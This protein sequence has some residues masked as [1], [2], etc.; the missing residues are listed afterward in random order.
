MSIQATAR[1]LAK[2]ID[3]GG[4]LTTQEAETFIRDCVRQ[5]GIG[6]HPDTAFQDYTNEKGERLFAK[7]NYGN[8]NLVMD[9]VAS[10]LEDRMYEIG[11][12]EQRKLAEGRG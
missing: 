3:E 8:L 11:L 4:K 7:L 2:R 10:T 1:R 12:E 9:H 5:I 6:F